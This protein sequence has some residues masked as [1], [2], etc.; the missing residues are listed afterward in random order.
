MGLVDHEAQE[1][2]VSLGLRAFLRKEGGELVPQHDG[3]LY[4]R[5][6]PGGVQVGPVEHQPPHPPGMAQSEGEGDVAAVAEAQDVGPF[7][8]LFVHEGRQVVRELGDGE[9]GRPPGGMAVAPGV[10]G[11]HGEIPGEFVHLVD[12]IVPVLPV[13]VEQEQGDARP[14]FDVMQGDVHD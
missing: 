10:H 8:A 5:P 11:V 2:G 1:L 4:G 9:G 7:N 14:L 12:E 3:Y 6:H 13:A